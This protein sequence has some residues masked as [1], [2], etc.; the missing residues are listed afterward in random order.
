MELFQS[1]GSIE[2]LTPQN[3]FGRL[4]D[5]RPAVPDEL[6]ARLANVTTEQAWKVLGQ[7]GFGHQFEGG[8]FESHPGV[9]LVGRAVTAAFVPFRPDLDAIVV[10]A[11]GKP[12]GDRRGSG[13][14][15]SWVIDALL[16]GDVIV[17]DMFGKVEDG[18][19][20]GDNLATTI[21][22]RTGAGA[23]I[24][25]MIRDYEGIQQIAPLQ[26][27]CRGVHP[28]FIRECTLVGVNMPLRI[29]AA[30]VMPG[31]VVLGTRTGVIFIPPQLAEEVATR[32][33][34]IARRDRF[35]K[36]RLADGRYSA[37]LMD[38]DWTREIEEDFRDWS[39]NP[40]NG[41]DDK[42]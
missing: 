8:W 14:Q 4:P 38:Q 2:A 39:A 36:Q 17:I 3:P 15:N 35:S 6:L 33:E 5:G 29:G 7:H 27:F 18:P 37:L 32:S 10:A 25:G 34:D 26:I 19:V 22:Q 1:P 13:G 11:S 28:S 30:T 40:A 23:V 41:H 21:S 12:A 31:D 9:V 24:E 42:P 16:P 20:V